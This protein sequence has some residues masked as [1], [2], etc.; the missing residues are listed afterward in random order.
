MIQDHINTYEGFLKIYENWKPSEEDF[1]NCFLDLKDEGFDVKVVFGGYYYSVIISRKHGTFSFDSVKETLLF[2]I[3]YIKDAYIF[4]STRIDVEY[5]NGETYTRK[6]PQ[7]FK[8]MIFD[9]R[10]NVWDKEI[11]KICDFFK[12]NNKV[13]N[14]ITNVN[15]SFFVDH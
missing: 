7:T 5:K 6:N 9:K 12:I 11:E 8:D 2:A 10:V 13:V 3:P 14:N 15:I 4:N 1:L